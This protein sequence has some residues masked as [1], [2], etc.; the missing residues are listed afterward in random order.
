LGVGGLL[1]VELG[2]FMGEVFFEG[3]LV[4]FVLVV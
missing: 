3:L 2:E 4:G 1:V